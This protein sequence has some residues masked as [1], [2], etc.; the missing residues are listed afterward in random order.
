[1][2]FCF[3]IDFKILCAK[4]NPRRP[5]AI[6]RQAYLSPHGIQIARYARVPDDIE[7][8]LKEFQ[9]AWKAVDKNNQT[10][11]KPNN[12]ADPNKANSSNEDDKNKQQQNPFG[13]QSTFIGFVAGVATLSIIGY[14]LNEKYREITWKTFI[15]SY[16][17]KDRVQR[18]EIVNK[19]WARVILNQSHEG[20]MEMVGLLLFRGFY[21][22]YEN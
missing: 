1:L 8:R 7:K 6:D 18:I 17:Y 10:P 15:N 13:D 12:D 3:S 11:N 16:L 22:S 4:S 2:D 20:P 5:S 21:A 14:Y 9:N 19:R